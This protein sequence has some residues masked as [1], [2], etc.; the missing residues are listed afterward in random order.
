[1]QS[2][3]SEFDNLGDSASDVS[4][5]TKKAESAVDKLAN[6]VAD[7]TD[8]T[9]GMS[10]AAQANANKVRVLANRHEQAKAK[11]EKLR[12]ELNESAEK[13]G[14]ASDETMRLAVELADA[15][16]EC[17]D[18]A[19][20]L[21]DVQDALDSTGEGSSSFLGKISSLFSGAAGDIAKGNLLSG[22]VSGLWDG[23]KGFASSVWSL[24]EA[25]EEY[26]VSQG[27]LNTAF[28]S[29]G[30]STKTASKIF[31][32]FYRILGDTDTATEAAQL[33][34][35]LSTNAQ[36]MSTWTEIAA[37]VYG[38][39]GDSLPIEGLI[40][41]SNETAKVGQV[42]GVLADA[43]N[44]VGIS[45]DD[46]N[47]KLQEC[48]T[49]EE[50]TALI[51]E[52]LSGKYKDA[53]TTFAE[54]N[55][56]VIAARD[57]QLKLQDAQA[58]VGEQV[59]RLKTALSTVL[60]P[61][62]QDILSLTEKLIGGAA[63]L[64][65]KWAWL[66]DKMENPI[67]TDN[68]EDAKAKLAEWQAKYDEIAASDD[69][70]AIS[71]QT[72]LDMY[73]DKIEKGTQQIEEM[74]ATQ[75]ALAESSEKTAEAIDKITVSANGFTVELA[76]SKLTV[77][78]ATEYLQSYTDA[79]TNMF[80]QISTESEYSYDQVLENMQHNIE[81]TNQFAENLQSIIGV[82]PASIAETFAT[83][84]PETYAGVVAMLAEANKGADE[85]LAQLNE[86]Y[87]EG[88]TAGAE[89]FITAFSE[90]EASITNNN[91]VKVMADA[92]QSDTSM[93]D[94]G[95]DAVNNTASKMESAVYTAGFYQAGSTAMQQ[96]LQGIQS[97]ESTIMAAVN[98]IA[99]K[100][101]AAIQQAIA[102]AQQAAAAAAA[103]AGGDSS[104]TGHAGG[105]D[106]VPYNGY[107]A[108]LHRGESVLTA[109][110]AEYLRSGRLNGI[111]SAGITI[112]QNIESVPQTPVELAEATAAYFEQAR[113]AIA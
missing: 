100:A 91:P 101:A 8:D 85:G 65:E 29:A 104:A 32:D 93:E 14:T 69:Y 25:T 68:I 105:L 26:R 37:G 78:E 57:S 30:Y 87:A 106:Y 102:A 59:S 72:M 107:P 109:T 2:A 52:T 71:K 49:A 15:E 39:F 60:S 35:Q 73:S 7:A 113:W 63:D 41:A 51:T 95:V 108:I 94:A 80:G 20:A 77:E 21:N 75:E 36:E 4:S 48:A 56:T 18:Y 42:T 12:K 16:E 64:A 83:G 111:N 62:M 24:D 76:N 112:V 22:V 17:R 53:A 45:E 89:A 66:V 97:M 9:K 44:W 28:Q 81:A 6:A 96:F 27:K 54:T 67:D 1:M 98:A 88:G 86:L 110:E 74:E 82:L 47:I 33:L 92:M 23:V 50:R 34:A 3:A 90:G 46:F 31:K 40:E 10:D 55:E 103:N 58:K 5:G 84:G 70:D 99:Q 11:V 19:N 13:T 79:A 43:L 38:T 61:A